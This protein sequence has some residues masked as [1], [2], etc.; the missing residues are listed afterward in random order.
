MQMQEESKN[1]QDVRNELGVK[2]VRLRVRI[3]KR[4]LERIGHIMRL[5]DTKMVKA[6]TLGW[7]EELENLPNMP[8][9]KRKTLM[10]WKKL[11][12]ED[13]IDKTRIGKLTSNRK[14][15]KLLVRE[16]IKHLEKWEERKTRRREGKET[17]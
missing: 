8:G 10:Y 1:M 13:G 17:K 3:E 16:R 9:K 4:C 12:K 15:W 7:M 14:E 11:L 6:V 2:S 5:E